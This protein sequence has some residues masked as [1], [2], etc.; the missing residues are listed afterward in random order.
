MLLAGLPFGEDPTALIY[1]S[2]P[3]L[4]MMRLDPFD[5]MN[6]RKWYSQNVASRGLSPNPDDPEHLYD[7]RAA[8]KSGASADPSGHMSSQ[9]KQIG[10]PRYFLDGRDTTTGQPT[11]LSS[12]I[13]DMLNK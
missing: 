7:Y 8:W 9:F 3:N 13:Q 1:T 2:S 6:F 10:H 12:I 4:L 11:G 5:E